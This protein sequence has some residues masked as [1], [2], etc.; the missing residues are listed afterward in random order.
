MDQVSVAEARTELEALVERVER[1]EEIVL[2]REGR[3][4]AKLIPADQ[5]ASEVDAVAIFRELR[6]ELASRGVFY[7]WEELKEF[8]DE[9]RP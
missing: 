5:P 8:R 7:S 1:G 4:V 3:S 2:T 9:G 6:K